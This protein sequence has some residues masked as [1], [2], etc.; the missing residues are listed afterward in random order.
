MDD[1]RLELM[2]KSGLVYRYRE[3]THVNAHLFIMLHGLSGDENA[4]WDLE[5]LY[6][7]DGF[8]VAPRGLFPLGDGKYSWV[9]EP[10]QGWPSTDDF[11]SAIAALKAL[12]G[13]LQD[14]FAIKNDPPVFMGFS[15]GAALAFG[16]ASDSTIRLQAIIAVAG[17]VPEGEYSELNGLPIF[18]GHGLK[19]QW[20]PIERARRDAR[21]LKDAGAEVHLCEADVGHKLGVECL[22]GLGG[23][24]RGLI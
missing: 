9:K 15:Q 17:F 10:L 19:D 12:I 3:A 13:E 5:H 16:V 7:V 21:L 1:P 22:Q 6:P 18:W 24:V 4:M 20:I 23:W 8:I 2:S 11:M 14:R